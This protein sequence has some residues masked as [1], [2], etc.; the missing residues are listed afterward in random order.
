MERMR[1]KG[2]WL[3]N[4]VIENLF[5]LVKRELLY[6]KKLKWVEDFIKEL[7]CYIKYYNRKGIK[8][9]VKGVSGVEQ[10]SKCELVG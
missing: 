6:L 2:N 7:K 8:I 9:K 4:G 3:D 1:G 5:G 10:R